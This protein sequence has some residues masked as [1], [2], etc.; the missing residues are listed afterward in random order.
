M[1]KT[2][3]IMSALISITALATP[4]V[5]A[6]DMSPTILIESMPNDN[7]KYRRVV[8]VHYLSANGVAMNFRAENRTEFKRVDVPAAPNLVASCLNGPATSLNEIRAFERDDKARVA[9]G[10]APEVRTFCIKGIPNWEAKNK[11]IYLDPIFET[12]PYSVQGY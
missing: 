11:D 10:Q 7:P 6:Q 1:R 3:L 12:M 5:S 9:R 4:N 8:L 2:G